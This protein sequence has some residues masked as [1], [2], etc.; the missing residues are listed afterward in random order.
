MRASYTSSVGPPP[1]LMFD[2]SGL[3]PGTSPAMSTSRTMPTSGL[4]A[5]AEVLAPRVPTSS[6]TVPTA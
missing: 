5:K 4:M 2:S 3:M 6:W 1:I